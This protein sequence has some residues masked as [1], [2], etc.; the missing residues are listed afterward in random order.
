MGASFQQQPDAQ[1]AAASAARAGFIYDDALGIVHYEGC[2]TCRR[3]MMHISD[4]ILQDSYTLALHQRDEKLRAQ[5]VEGFRRGRSAQQEHDSRRLRDYRAQRDEARSLE[6]AYKLK[7]EEA[8]EQVAQLREELLTLQIAYDELRCPSPQDRD[9]LYPLDEP[10]L[11]D[12]MTFGD[13]ASDPQTPDFQDD[14]GDDDDKHTSSGSDQGDSVNFW[15]DVDIPDN[16]YD[17]DNYD[18]ESDSTI[19]SDEDG[20]DVKPAVKMAEGNDNAPDHGPALQPN[21][22][23]FAFG[24]N[25]ANLPPRPFQF[26]LAS[27]QPST[28]LFSSSQPS[29]SLFSSSRPSTSLFSSSPLPIPVS[30]PEKDP[31]ADIRE[32]MKLAHDPDNTE[33]LAHVK[34]LVS[35]AHQTNPRSRTEI[36]KVLL[37]EWRRPSSLPSQ[38]LL[39]QSPPLPSLRLDE[40]VYVDASGV[41][42][43]FVSGDIWQA[44]QWKKTWKWDGRDIQW[45]EAVAAEMGIRLMIAS[46]YSGKKIILY[47]D[48][49][50]VVD[51]V[52]GERSIGESHATEIVNKIDRLCQEYDIR[53]EIKWVPGEQNPADAPSR[54]ILIGCEK[55][56]HPYQVKIPEYLQEFV[57]PWV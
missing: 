12:I 22:F 21:T 15:G 52:S 13:E 7:L 39:S 46:G 23:S 57:L 50:Q 5:F 4:P 14:S 11:S 3:Y 6:T 36:Q 25:H 43:G 48:N 56:R 18:T 2:R 40:T 16:D 32:Q 33:I 38:S 24:G 49:S 42:I 51:A 34:S 55:K 27:P 29:T 10:E 20:L 37:T 45:A 8:N 53:L 9:T 35:E 19:P 1:H 54:L 44:W 17:D 41:G 30:V 28:S 47:S 26:K 31:L